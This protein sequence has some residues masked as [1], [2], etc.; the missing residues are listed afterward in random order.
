MSEP[1]LQKNSAFTAADTNVIK[2]LALMALLFHHLFYSKSRIGM[3]TSLLGLSANGTPQLMAL[4]AACKFCVAMF[5]I[6][7]GYGLNAA[8]NQR[9]NQTGNA[10][11]GLHNLV[12][13]TFHSLLK[14]MTSYW[15]IFVIFVPFGFLLGR[16]P[17][18]IY[19]GIKDF[20]I[21]FLGLANLFGTPSM[22]DTWWFMSTIIL[23]YLLFP[24]LKTLTNYVPSCLL[25]SATGL[26]YLH[27]DTGICRWTFPFVLG[28]YLSQIDIFEI[29]ENTLS[30]KNFWRY[31]F[32]LCAVALFCMVFWHRLNRA[33]GYLLETP[34]ALCAILAGYMVFISLIGGGQKL[35]HILE[36][37]G[38]YSG[39]IFMFHTFI[40]TYYFKELT[41]VF[42]YPLLIWL[43]L[44]VACMLIAWGLSWLKAHIG[45]N[46]LTANAFYQTRA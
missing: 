19:F 32:T 40:Y 2:G 22:N 13:T 44:L 16:S 39:D 11:D 34:L 38:R 10:L 21:D 23:C 35:T 14:L 31:E 6:L 1:R 3:Y 33:D 7:S 41:Y 28:M 36:L 29:I 24:V 12:Q 17:L 8:Y 18:N 27:W 43:F 20:L 25:L 15:L 5:L 9:N 37:L 30:R 26:A 46:R 45:I 42:R 4:A